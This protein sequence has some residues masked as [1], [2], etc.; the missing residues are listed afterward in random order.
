M[1]AQLMRVLYVDGYN[2][3]GAWPELTRSRTMADARDAL[4]E[5]LH[6]Y[7]GYTNQQ[8]IAVF[9]AWQGGRRKATSE[10]M[11]RLK[12][13][14]TQR[15]ETADHYIERCCHQSMDAI[16]RGALEVRVATSD[17][18]IQTIILG[19]GATR[20]SARELIE[21]ITASHKS[22]DTHMTWRRT[23]QPKKNTVMDQLPESVRDQLEKL[24]RGDGR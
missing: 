8:V 13:V 20:M 4:I 18:L 7:A 3:L 14:Y 10:V 11:S 6:D 12:V 16:A 1:A 22:I 23:V 5:E 2:I 9:D 19:R 17:A 21:E 24:R 15:G